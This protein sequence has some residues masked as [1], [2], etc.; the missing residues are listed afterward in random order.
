MNSSSA[1][2]ITDGPPAIGVVIG[3]SSR[4]TPFVKGERTV[5]L[6]DVC[7]DVSDIG[8][9]FRRIDLSIF[10]VVVVDGSNRPDKGA[11]TA[12]NC[13]AQRVV[14]VVHVPAVWRLI[15]SPVALYACSVFLYAQ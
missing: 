14:F 6:E 15:V 11:A 12:G 4:A 8:M 9:A 5:V 1:A 2:A 10:S 7:A 3:A 13:E